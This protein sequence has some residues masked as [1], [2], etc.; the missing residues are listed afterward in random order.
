MPVNVTITTHG[1]PDPDVVAA[2]AEVF[3]CE[4]QWVHAHMLAIAP[5]GQRHAVATC[6]VHGATTCQ[7][8]PARAADAAAMRRL[9]GL[10]TAELGCTCWEPLAERYGVGV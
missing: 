7:W 6:D 3:G 5:P 4:P 1:E 2:L 8:E 10:L 9:F